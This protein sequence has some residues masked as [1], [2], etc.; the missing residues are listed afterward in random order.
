M[1]IN[2]RIATAREDKGFTLIELLIVI[3]VI[4]ILAGIA[5]FA[6]GAF[7]SDASNACSKANSRINAG[8]SAAASAASTQAS[9]YIAT[10]GNC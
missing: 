1:N 7:R 10:G 9:S 4:G 5:I 8:A 6:V 2:Q 3:V